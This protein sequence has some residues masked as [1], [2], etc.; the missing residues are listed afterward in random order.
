MTRLRKLQITRE[1]QRVSFCVHSVL[2]TQIHATIQILAGRTI[3]VNVIRDLEVLFVRFFQR[4][5]DSVTPI[6]IHGSITMMV[7]IAALKVAVA[8]STF[9]VQIHHSRF[10]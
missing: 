4:Q 6:L 8:R 5:I 2:T 3:P 10:M 7:V 1:R 9:V